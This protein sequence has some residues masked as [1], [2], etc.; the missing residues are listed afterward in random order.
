MCVR[1][2]TTWARVVRVWKTY[3]EYRAFSVLCVLAVFNFVPFL[4]PRA[5]HRTP[6]QTVLGLLAKQK[7]KYLKT[8]RTLYDLQATFYGYVHRD[9]I[10]ER[11]RTCTTIP[12]SIFV[13][14]IVQCFIWKK[15]KSSK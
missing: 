15:E 13:R 4:P 11:H 9:A 8:R 7:K 12:R 6:R 3:F 5:A 14:T 10:L 2:R 1:R